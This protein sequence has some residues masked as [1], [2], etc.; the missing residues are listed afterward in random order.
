M[1]NKLPE[2]RREKEKMLYFN[3][4]RLAA[5]EAIKGSTILLTRTDPE[6]N[7]YKEAVAIPDTIQEF[8]YLAFDNFAQIVQAQLEEKNG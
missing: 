3:D 8:T 7:S 6:G 4:D 5:F 2:T 1:G